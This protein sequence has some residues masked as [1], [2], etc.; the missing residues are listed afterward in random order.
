MRRSV[1]VPNTVSRRVAFALALLG[2]ARPLAAQSGERGPIQDNSFLIEEAYNQEPAVMQTIQTFS[3]ISGTGEWLYTITQE[4]PVPGRKHQLSFMLPILRNEERNKG[5]GDLL[6]NY[7][8]QLVGDGEAK[9]ACAPRVSLVVPTGMSDRGL[10]SGGWGAQVM[11]PVSIVLAEWLVS[12][13][14]VGGTI[15]FDAKSGDDRVLTLGQS[16][17]WLAHPNV[18]LMLEG[19]LNH[20]NGGRDGDS[21]TDIT[22]APGLRFALNLPG[23]L[24]I[25]PGIAYT[26]GVGSSA[27]QK[28]VFLYLS[29]EHPFRKLTPRI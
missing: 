21:H 5:A 3:R 12:H 27:G 14:N 24:Q 1:E 26:F 6:L 15:L 29:F 18:N 11:L 13:T 25:V 10:G 28:G 19:I 9:I 7:R 20:G 16:L 8:Y 4:F 23:G 22:L 2:L 17:I